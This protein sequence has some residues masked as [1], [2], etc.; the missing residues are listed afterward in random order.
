MRT[1]AT[2]ERDILLAQTGELSAARAAALTRHVATCP[3]C[4]AF[5]VESA[6]LCR[7]V[8]A[9]GAPPPSLPAATWARLRAVQPEPSAAYWSGRLFGPR[10]TWAAAAA[11]LLALGLWWI[12]PQ[13]GVPVRSADGAAQAVLVL[14]LLSADWEAQAAEL[15][16][17]LEAD[18]Q[19]G[20]AR[21]WEALDE[22][23]RELIG[24]EQS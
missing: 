23:A 20:V 15:E 7:R 14:T 3:A 16:A 4:R 5:G 10:L 8:Q 24:G 18:W 21:G 13:P 22:L 1:C 11:L 9:V 17:T 6:A 12:R 2:W 19:P